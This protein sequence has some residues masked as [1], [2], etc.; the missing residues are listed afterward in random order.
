[1]RKVSST[2][3]N[4]G[5]YYWKNNHLKFIWQAVII[6]I[7]YEGVNVLWCCG[8]QYP[9]YILNLSV[10]YWFEIRWNAINQVT[11]SEH[12]IHLSQLLQHTVIGW[13][14]GKILESWKRIIKMTNCGNDKPDMMN[15]N[16]DTI[17]VSFPIFS[18]WSKYFP[19]H[20]PK[21]LILLIWQFLCTDCV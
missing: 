16:H 13:V 14:L 6:F 2:W 19:S 7:L 5:S 9:S 4:F 3:A 17:S 1:M 21:V 15:L 12:P 20:F 8:Q 11:D 18:W 10:Y